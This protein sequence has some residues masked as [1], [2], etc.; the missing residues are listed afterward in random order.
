MD[1]TAPIQREPKP[2]HEARTTSSATSLLS[3]QRSLRL[4]VNGNS[5]FAI[6]LILFSIR[7]PDSLPSQR[8]SGSPRMGSPDSRLR[9]TLRLLGAGEEI[10]ER[11]PEAVQSPGNQV[12]LT[13]REDEIHHLLSVVVL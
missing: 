11:H 1:E 10:V 8:L 7:L 3:S 2:R 13:D 6:G 12:V 4:L 5:A 9:L